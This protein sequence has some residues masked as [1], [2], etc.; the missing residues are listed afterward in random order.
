[1]HADVFVPFQ[2]DLILF[3]GVNISYLMFPFVLPIAAI[4]CG[5]QRLCPCPL[6]YF[7]LQT[8]TMPHSIL[9]GH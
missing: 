2:D 3:Y 6:S 8:A 4:L 9:S 5:R 7:L 1:M